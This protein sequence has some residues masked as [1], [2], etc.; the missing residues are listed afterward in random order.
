MLLGV[1]YKGLLR[2][3][4][5]LQ[6][7]NKTA[8]VEIMYHGTS[9]KLAGAI[10]SEGLVPDRTLVWDA[11]RTKGEDRSRESYGG[12]YLT[13]NFMTAYGAALTAKE[14]FGGNRMIV[15]VQAE[16]RTPSILIDEDQLVDPRMA[17]NT[18]MGIN[19]NDWWYCQWAANDFL[20]IDKVVEAYL[21][22]L[23][24]NSNEEIKP[25]FEDPRQLEALRPAV[26]EFIMSS[27]MREVAIVINQER[28]FNSFNSIT[29]KYPQFAEMD[30]SVAESE[31]RTVANELMRKI[32][33]TANNTRYFSHNVRTM[34]PISFSGR[35]K[36]IL[37]AR[38]NEDRWDA[39]ARKSHY[40][41][42]KYNEEAEILYG[43]DSRAIQMLSNDLMTRIGG[44][45]RVR[46]TK[47]NVYF[48]NPRK[49]A[50]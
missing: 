47:G 42:D 38:I 33:F 16:L 28:S 14:Q 8:S 9:D 36:I 7:L 12:I 46:D 24:K 13:N 17:I 41:D 30:L 22:I 34:E 23:S 32:S 20:G 15:M 40:I 50:A 31:Y 25:G 39:E 6:R 2:S 43:N 4:N 18:S 10:M 44:G 35:N 3:M 11:A 21:D 29:H 26:R 5:W 1:G 27:T 45:I 19:A 37:V 49:E 48:D